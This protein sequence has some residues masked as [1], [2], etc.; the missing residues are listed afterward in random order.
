M[1]GEVLF[2]SVSVSVSEQRPGRAR[3]RREVDAIW[4]GIA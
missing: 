3:N 1:L 2:Y 4:N